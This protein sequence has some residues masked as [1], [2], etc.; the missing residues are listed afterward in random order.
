VGPGNP[1]ST[2]CITYIYIAKHFNTKFGTYGLKIW[3]SFSGEVLKQNLIDFLN[4]D[5]L[6]SPGQIRFITK[7]IS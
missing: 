2:L 6:D 4:S 3:M 1:L 5:A 7:E